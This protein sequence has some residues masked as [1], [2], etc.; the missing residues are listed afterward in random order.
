MVVV[1]PAPFGPRKPKNSAS[2]TSMDKFSRARTSP[3]D[4]FNPLMDIAGSIK[5]P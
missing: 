1:F 3:Y 5:R 4:L 2:P